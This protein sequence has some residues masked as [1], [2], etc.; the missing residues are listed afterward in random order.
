MQ[1]FLLGILLIAGSMLETRPA[2]A[3][4]P[5]EEAAT[6]DPAQRAADL[7]YLASQI[8]DR[9]PAPYAF[10]DASRW[11]QQLELLEQGIDEL[12][13]DGFYFR[14]QQVAAL[15]DDIHTSAF[16]LPDQG[17][18]LETYPVRF[19]RFGDDIHVR[20]VRKDLAWLLGARVVEINGRSIER[21][22]EMIRGIAPG[23]Q[24]L[25]HSNVPLAYLATPAVY[26]YLGF[27]GGRRGD[28][29]EVVTRSGQRRTVRLAAEPTSLYA[30]Y[31]SG[32]VVGWNVPAGWVGV[33]DP[34]DASTPI[35]YRRRG[36]AEMVWFEALPGDEA[37]LVQVNQPRPDPENSVVSAMASLYS[38][39]STH[40]YRRIVIDLRGNEGGW[41]S[42]TSALPGIVAS[43]EAG[44]ERPAVYVLIG[45]D[46]TSAGVA[47]A[48][49]LEQQTN[50]VF[51]GEPTGSAPNM[52]GTYKPAQLPGSGIYYRISTARL[53]NSLPEDDRR[54]VAPDVSVIERIEDI[55]R[56]VDVA[57]N[58]ALALPLQAAN[59][60]PV[61]WFERW[62]RPSQVSA[63]Q[64]DTP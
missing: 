36:Q 48:V 18:L 55:D 37:L 3:G 33:A 5:A 23:N 44:E 59:P 51:V 24:R 1:V 25:R 53:L 32:S 42:L 22:M 19:R 60:A 52:F 30:A 64:S 57:L 9:H 54:W 39:L 10:T 17:L 46:T 28:A 35:L 12:D 50:A 41:Y 56:G 21:V 29:F 47:L 62:K 16:P 4:T 8:R 7:R 63:R 45:P 38:H 13:V 61:H 34:A 20:A 2:H 14:L 58:E 40:R 49:Q 6:H 43:I 11:D 26:R 31:E 15:V 27:P